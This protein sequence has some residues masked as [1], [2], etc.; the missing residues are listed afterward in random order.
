[1]TFLG[2]N[3]SLRTDTNF[4]NRVDKECYKG[5]SSLIRLPIDMIKNVLSDYLHVVLLGVVKKLLKFW[6]RGKQSLIAFFIC[7]HCCI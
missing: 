4:R 7:V 3:S 5:D 1:M 6:V 2:I